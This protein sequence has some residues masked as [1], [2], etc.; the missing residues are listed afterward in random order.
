[1]SVRA[2]RRKGKPER[3][4]QRHATWVRQKCSGCGVPCIIAEE[5]YG[6]RLRAALLDA[7][8]TPRG[9]LV[10]RPDGYV[11]RD[12]NFAVSGPRYAFHD[13]PARNA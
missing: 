10:R 9:F 12:A 11:M 1:M 13:C 6:G 2:K 8:R 4:P 5:D 3:Q 7:A